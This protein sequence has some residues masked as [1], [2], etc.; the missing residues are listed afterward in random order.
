[1]LTFFLFAV[2]ESV[3]TSAG[4]MN[5]ELERN[6]NTSATLPTKDDIVCLLH[7]YKEP[8]AQ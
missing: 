1:V 6:T 5:E 8:M 3:A 2:T 4:T 7:L